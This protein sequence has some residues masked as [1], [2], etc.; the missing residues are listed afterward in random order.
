MTIYEIAERTK[1]TA[2]HFFD[3]STLRFFGQTM[4]DFF[5]RKTS[6]RDLLHFCH[7]QRLVRQRN[8]KN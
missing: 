1:E 3:G 6:G 5:G 8:G 4:A 7:I 2:P